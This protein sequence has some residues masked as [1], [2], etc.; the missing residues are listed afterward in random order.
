MTKI[1]YS[2]ER[3]RSNLRMGIFFVTIGIILVLLSFIIKWKEISLASIGIGQILAGIPM[4]MIYYFENKKQY[5]TLKNGELIKNA[6]FPKKIKLKEV[7]SIREFAGDLKLITEKT[8]FIIDTQI[9]E[10]NSL[11]ELKNELKNYNLK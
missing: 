6:L 10:P 1:R 9:V 8:E 11:M 5:L 4:F 7:K 2:K 3:L